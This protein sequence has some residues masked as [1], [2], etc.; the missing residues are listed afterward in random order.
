MSAGV[1]IDFVGVGNIAPCP[2][3][4]EPSPPVG[5]ADILSTDIEHVGPITRVLQL[6]D[7]PVEAA[8]CEA[9]DVLSS[10]P[11]GSAFSDD[12]EPFGEQPGPGSV[13]A[14][15]C[16]IGDACVLARR[17]P[18]DDGGKV[19]EA[20]A[21]SVGCDGSDIVEHLRI[22]ELAG[23]HGPAPRVELGGRHGA[24]ARPVQAQAPAANSAAEKIEDRQSVHAHS[25]SVRPSNRS[26]CARMESRIWR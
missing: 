8:T 5:G 9:R 15:S 17:A 4:P 25:S 2:D 22:G 20:S 13:E 16:V 10:A 23:E 3:D 12:A 11:N 7:H 14:L 19:S 26:P 18:D 1:T 21:K 24:V 6:G